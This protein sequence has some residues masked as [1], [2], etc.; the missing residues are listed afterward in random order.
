MPDPVRLTGM[1][2]AIPN[3]STEDIRFVLEVRDDNPIYC[4]VD[5]GTASEIASGLG[6][7]IH[8]LRTAL[9]AKGSVVP[10][11]AEHLSRV[12]VDRD[13][14]SG[15]VVMTVTT[16]AGAQSL[17]R[18]PTQVALELSDQLKAEAL[19]ANP[20]AGNA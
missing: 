9:S 14:L 18:F 16:A 3:G 8:L 12:Y 11:S 20:P 2:Q 7:A 17:F 4:V 15:D 6:I 13:L 10:V 19:K 5:Y 1:P